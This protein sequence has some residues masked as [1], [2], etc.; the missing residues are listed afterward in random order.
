MVSI[1]LTEWITLRPLRV[2]SGFDN[3]DSSKFN[4][5]IHLFKYRFLT[6][7]ILISFS[8]SDSIGVTSIAKMFL[9][10]TSY[11]TF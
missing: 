4:S 9:A 1:A 2:I 10:G 8:K 11:L 3:L 6:F 5:S 7:N